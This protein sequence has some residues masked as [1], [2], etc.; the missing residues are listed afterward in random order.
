MAWEEL[1]YLIPYFASS[2]FSSPAIYLFSYLFFF[3][4]FQLSVSCNSRSRNHGNRPFLVDSL[5]AYSQL[6]IDPLPFYSNS[7]S[8][9]SSMLARN[10]VISCLV[11]FFASSWSLVLSSVSQVLYISH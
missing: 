9:P 10:L 8:F 2:P 11:S 5:P 4:P 1:F 6:D 3:P 7:R